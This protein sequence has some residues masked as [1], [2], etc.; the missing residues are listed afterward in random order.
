MN[1]KKSLVVLLSLAAVFGCSEK[2]STQDLIA[3]SK[4]QINSG[5]YEEGIIQLKNAARQSPK[6]AEVR[7]LLARA[8]L[9]QGN[10]ASAAKEL[11]VAKK[12]KIATNL[13]DTNIVRAYFL[14]DSF[15]DIIALEPSSTLSIEE[16]GKVAAYKA[17][18]Y[19][20]TGDLEGLN[21]AFTIAEK[22]GVNS[23]FLAMA[24]VAKF[25]IEKDFNR[26]INTAKSGFRSKEDYPEFYRIE[27]DAL[28]ANKEFS[29]AAESLKVYLES[30]PE[31]LHIK[32]IL[33]EVYLNANQI[34]EAEYHANQIL[35]LFPEH[36]YA[37]YLLA[38]I[39]LMRADY[40][41]ANQFAE[42]AYGAGNTLPHNRLVAGVSA[43]H[44]QK[45]ERAYFHLSSII[46]V[47]I[48]SHPARKMYAV[49]QLELGQVGDIAESLESFEVLNEADSAFVSSLG[50]Q[51]YKIGAKEDA[52]KLTKLLG[53]GSDEA[54]LQRSVMQLMMNDP[55]SIK[56]LEQ[57][58][59][60]DNDLAE[61]KLLLAFAKS[62]KG[63]L[64][65]AIEL[66]KEWRNENPEK[67]SGR[68]FL[69]SL[70]ERSGNVTSALELLN[71]VVA[72]DNKNMPARIE[73]AR[74]KYKEGD[75][76]T[77]KSIISDA[78]SISPENERALTLNFAI[79]KDNAA[80][81]LI[82]DYATKNLTNINAQMMVA[83][84]L[85]LQNKNED[86]LAY[87]PDSLFN[88]RSPKRAWQL[89]SQILRK[90]Q[91]GADLRAHVE[92]WNEKNPYH[93]EAVLILADFHMRER[94]YDD[95]LRTINKAL[96]GEHKGNKGLSLAKLELLLDQGDHREAERLFVQVKKMGIVT[97]LSKGI[98]GRIQL[99]K[100]KYAQAAQNLSVF[101]AEFP[102]SK[103][104]VMLSLALNKSN[105]VEKG[106]E[107]LES[108]LE[109]QPNDL[110]VKNLLASTYLNTS[111]KKAMSVY[112]K[113][114]E[115]QPHNLVAL[116]NLAFLYLEIDNVKDA[117]SLIEQ[118]VAINKNIPAIL[119]TYSRVLAKSGDIKEALVQSKLAFDKTKGEDVDIALQYSELLQLNNRSKR[120]AD[121]LSSI[122]AKTEEQKTKLE[123]LKN[124]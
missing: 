41:V 108:F 27:A 3:K 23:E 99:L 31:A 56:S 7:L 79:N 76:D 42:K 50:M 28:I 39:H 58:L 66:T 8:Y 104:A 88:I 5:N 49:S 109:R 37:N 105:Q 100:Q 51:L 118:A 120:A 71:Q 38:S 113:I 16:A 46:D 13:Y 92:N 20:R 89:K 93:V 64:E 21:E 119:D 12:L 18:A 85:M 77:A 86:A 97:P 53:G 116:N 87:L 44:V 19:W 111:K 110:R 2:E 69:A 1:K 11:D 55:D 54:A 124:K 10:G 90:L 84:A 121:V 17:Y 122:D 70:Y 22:E 67:A 117:K 65:E 94:K 74:L 4:Q 40:E 59:S 25:L 61:N 112:E 95:A 60:Q 29:K 36:M 15:E 57:R 80:L 91:R 24:R 103:N 101:Y 9:A 14:L 98:E 73:L 106:V 72:A 47:L 26:A 114:V 123:A 62:Q 33:A 115:K 81:K 52:K 6:D 43:F 75:I 30:Q 102:S 35:T 48:P 34:D 107:V 63:D 45:F 78:I 82:K 83:I 32:L 96:K 68:I